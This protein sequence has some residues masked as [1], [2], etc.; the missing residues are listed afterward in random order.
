MGRP[1]VYCDMCGR[2]LREEE[3]DRGKA[4][5]VE[6]RSFCIECRPMEA[7]AAPPLLS[8]LTPKSF[9]QISSTRIARLPTGHTPREPMELPSLPSARAPSRA[10]LFAGIAVGAIVLVILAGVLLSGGGKGGGGNPGGP[11][12]DVRVT[13]AA[14]KHTDGGETLSPPP[15]PPPASEEPAK[16]AYMKAVEIRK[17]SPD[18]LAGQVQAFEEVVQRHGTSSVAEVARGE[19]VRI[20]RRMSDEIVQLD[21]QARSLFTDE[22]YKTA[23]DLW[24]RARARYALPDWTG[25][26]DGKIR[27]ANDTARSRFP[28]IR[29]RGAEARKL[30]QADEVK[31]LRERILRWGMPSYVEDFDR[32]IAAVVLNQPDV[33]PESLKEA[34]LYRAAW[35]DAMDLAARRDYDGAGQ[36]IAKASEPLKDEGLKKEAAVDAALIK[37]ASA[38]VGESRT[39]LAKLAKGQKVTLSFTD[40]S[41]A[42]ATA[43]GT[44]AATDGHRIELRK[45]EESVVVL[46]GEIGLAKPPADARTAA[47]LC[48]LDGDGEGA[49]KAGGDLPE[50]YALLASEPKVADPKEVEAR[51]LFAQAEAEYFD[52]ARTVDAIKGYKSLLSG[53]SATGF[54]NR[55]KGAIS[56]RLEG[57]KE[58]FLSVAELSASSNFK[59]A[60]HGIVEAWI[61]TKDLEATGLKDSY[62]EIAFSAHAETE[63]RLWVQVGGCCQEV[64]A[65][66]VQGTEL[67]APNPKKPAEMIPVP[68]GGEAV[69]MV[70]MPY[71]ALKKRHSDHTGPKE[72]DKWE[73]IPIVLQ[74]YPTAGTKSVR[75]LTT[76]KGLS[77][78]A[79]MVS[80]LRPGPPRPADLAEA[81]KAKTEVPGYSALRALS[82]TGGILREWWTDISGGDLGSLTGNPKFQGPP[83]GT[84]FETSFASPVDV[85]DNYGS[86]MRGWVH[87]PATGDYVFWI[88]GDDRGEL[89][90]ST[91]DRPENRR[92]IATLPDY[93]APNEWEKSG[94][95]KSKPIGLVAG[96]RYYIEALHKEG[97]GGDSVSAGWQLPDGKQER[98]IPGNRLSPWGGRKK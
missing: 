64:L 26:V 28:A 35:K 54:V 42:R 32:T 53:F 70:K 5:T 79:A 18:D 87:A 52:P 38:S 61:S 69:G 44:V 86:R 2:M 40:D 63:Y 68:I 6:N 10:P 29:A 66:L 22:A 62:V 41:G 76:Q 11:E 96:R 16:A 33:P 17:S 15:P 55:N 49:K 92:K 77:V 84:S 73:W 27:E 88:A 89:W 93:T 82:R 91:D 98:P 14:P 46:V 13:G 25:P 95:Q 31:K 80:A 3:F 30:N 67:S 74:K 50:K 34:G 51:T 59:Q 85:M 71:S 45:G 94:A 24:Q 47:F 23:I 37:S 20:R 19:I 4:H 97:G 1:V 7:S 90:L 72:P 60:K 21:T 48:I 81:E 36:A 56:S 39:L 58:Y 57:G 12:V 78:A 8:P 65:A 83:S 43:E 9:K 75:L